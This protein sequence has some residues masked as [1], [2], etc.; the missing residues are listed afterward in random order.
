[1]RAPKSAV[2]NRDVCAVELC[3]ALPEPG[4]WYCVGHK[5]AKR[6]QS[7]QKGSTCKACDRMLYE[8]DFV[9]RESTPGNLQH[10]VCPAPAPRPKGRRH[11]ETPLF[12]GT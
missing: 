9:T 4:S 10:A 12:D 1:M 11:G 6:L 7:V 8:G 3:P 5:T 2:D